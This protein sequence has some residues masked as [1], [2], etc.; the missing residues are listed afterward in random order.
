MTRTPL[1]AP[2]A[3]ALALASAGCVQITG[4]RAAQLD[5]IG[6]VALTTELCSEGI[7]GETRRDHEVRPS[8]TCG[9]NDLGRAQLL[10][11][12]RVPETAEPVG[13]PSGHALTLSASY[14]AALEAREPAGDDARWVAYAGEAAELGIARLRG[15]VAPRFPLP[16][17]RPY[18]GPFPYRTDVGY[19]SLAAGEDP[20]A[21]IDCAAA[22]TACAA[23]ERVGEL[24]TRD[25]ALV[26]G[27][28]VTVTAG[29]TARVPFRAVFAGADDPGL[30]FALSAEKVEG[31]AAAPEAPSFH[32]EPDGETPLF[33]RVAVPRDA[34]PGRRRVRV[35]ARLANGQERS[36]EAA[37][38]VVAP[39]AP[40]EPAAHTPPA[41]PRLAVT[42][43]SR[44]CLSRRTVRVR[45]RRRGPSDTAPV[46]SVTLNGRPATF[47]T[48]GR[49]RLL[50]DLRGLPRS[51]YRIRIA[52][53][54]ADGSTLVDPRRYRTCAPKRPQRLR[55]LPPLR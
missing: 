55:G 25:L 50:V 32:P 38:V 19:R 13:S 33:V 15:E 40:P 28:E 37:F 22:G 12:H 47:R 4:E 29:E 39:D 26:A 7:E 6:D 46:R 54:L 51:R 16:G 27:D 8:G 18:A 52:A 11:A 21:P 23:D 30:E 41:E 44:A 36:G 2:L 31:L 49:T 43:S 53:R 45:L 48:Q 34:A 1:L 17:G 3:A 20:A 5:L 14:A 24:P 10:L 35:S 9:I 42:E